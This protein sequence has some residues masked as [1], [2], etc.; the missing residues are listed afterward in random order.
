MITVQNQ[1]GKIWLRKNRRSWALKDIQL[2]FFIEWLSLDHLSKDGKAII[3]MFK[4]KIV[5]MN[6][7]SMS[8]WD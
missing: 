5:G 2:L 4:D 1:M 6:R 3:K 8:G 7:G